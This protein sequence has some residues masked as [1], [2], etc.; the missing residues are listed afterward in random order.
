MS[1]AAQS[2]ILVFALTTSL[3]TAKSLELHDCGLLKN[4]FRDSAVIYDGVDSIYFLGGH[5]Y[6][7][8]VDTVVKF[9]I[10]ANTFETVGKFP[11]ELYGGVATLDDN[12]DILYFGGISLS[13]AEYRSEQIFKI[14]RNNPEPIIMMNFTDGTGRS[15]RGVVRV[16]DVVYIFGGNACGNFENCKIF[17]VGKYNITANT[18]EDVASY[19]VELPNLTS[20]SVAYDGEFVYI[21]GGNLRYADDWSDTILRFNPK[22]NELG[23]IESKL[24]KGITESSSFIVDDIAYVIPGY[25]S[26]EFPNYYENLLA[27][28][29]KTQVV[30]EID[31]TGHIA[32]VKAASAYVPKQNRVYIFGLTTSVGSSYQPRQITC[33]DFPSGTVECVGKPDGNYPHPTNCTKFITCSNQ[34]KYEMNCPHGLHFNSNLLMCD[35]PANANCNS[36][37]IF[38]SK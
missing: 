1:V 35:Y 9:D 14:R 10:V 29:T 2:L 23:R 13:N 19:P 7:H 3:L 30:S 26:V 22:T 18:V 12:G 11:Y 15:T 5:L 27:F 20:I 16:E 17:T 34:R 21:F 6:D 24:P 4:E 36:I 38:S 31:I 25:A 8:Y 28:N 33:I 32:R 37:S